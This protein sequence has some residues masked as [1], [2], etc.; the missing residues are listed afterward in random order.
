MRQRVHHQKPTSIARHIHH[1]AHRVFFDEGYM[2]YKCW[3]HADVNFGVP[4][5]LAVDWNRPVDEGAR[6]TSK[7]KINMKSE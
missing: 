7:P 4:L 6:W 5:A 3:L 2:S 1:R